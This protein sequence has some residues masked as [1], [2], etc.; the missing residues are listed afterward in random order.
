MIFRWI[1][2]NVK[3]I[4]VSIIDTSY[5]SSLIAREICTLYG[6][7]AMNVRTAGRWFLSF[8]ENNF[9]LKDIDRSGHPFEFDEER[10]N[11]LLHKNARQST[12]E[13]AQ[14]M[15]Y[16]HKNVVN[17]LHS[18]KRFQNTALGFHMPWVKRTK[19]NEARLLPICYL[20]FDWHVVIS[21]VFFIA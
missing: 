17:H 8:K 20:V 5:W 16:D 6:K 21:N 7:D 1:Q 12:R 18:I 3:L 10:L 13:L 15:E 11:Q 19:I 2:W 14:Q 4:K 9:E